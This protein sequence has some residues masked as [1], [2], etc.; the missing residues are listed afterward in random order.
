MPINS[1]SFGRWAVKTGPFFFHRRIYFGKL[2]TP[3]VHVSIK[4][5]AITLHS[6]LK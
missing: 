1:L 4:T 6:I 3:F 2:W 5:C